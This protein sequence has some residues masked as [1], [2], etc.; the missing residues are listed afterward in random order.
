[1]RLTR[2]ILDNNIKT[3]FLIRLILSGTSKVN[4]NIKALTDLNSVKFSPEFIGGSDGGQ[5]TFS[6]IFTNHAGIPGIMK[7][8]ALLISIAKF[9]GNPIEERIST[10]V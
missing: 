5:T 3:T 7:I 10:A 9:G 2:I 4:L 1:M 6:A 8:G